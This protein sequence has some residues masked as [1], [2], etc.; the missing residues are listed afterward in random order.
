MLLN[1]SYTPRYKVIQYDGT[2]DIDVQNVSD[3]FM[4]LTGPQGSKFI[5]DYAS[6]QQQ[7]LT[8]GDWVIFQPSIE[9]VDVFKL[10]VS[11]YEFQ[12]DYT[13]SGVS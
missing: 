12:R 2:N 4:I 6:G 5:H 8:P 1:A 10:V 13:L 7:N 11:D 3:T 9:G